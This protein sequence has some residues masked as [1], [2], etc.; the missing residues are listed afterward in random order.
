[1]RIYVLYDY[2]SVTAGARE[3][4]RVAQSCPRREPGRGRTAGTGARRACRLSSRL[5]EE[6]EELEMHAHCFAEEIL[7]FWFGSVGAWDRASAPPADVEAR[8]WNGG[9]TLDAELTRRYR[10]HVIAAATLFEHETRWAMALPPGKLTDAQQRLLDADSACAERG[11]PA[12]PALEPSTYTT[13]EVVDAKHDN[14]KRESA[15]QLI[16]DLA[17]SFIQYDPACPTARADSRARIRDRLALVILLDQFS[18]NI[19]RGSSSAFAFDRFACPL[20]TQLLDSEG[21]LAK[22]YM[23]ALAPFELFFLLMPLEHSEVAAEQT[24]GVEATRKLLEQVQAAEAPSSGLPTTRYFSDV[25]RDKAGRAELVKRFGRY[26]PRNEALGRDS[27]KAE[28]EYLEARQKAMADGA[29]KGKD[30]SNYIHLPQQPA[31]D[32]TPRL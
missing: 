5:A 26:P 4:A 13:G 29:A 9:E 32:T 12:A 2:T 20:V 23:E 8:W 27:T 24:A 19:Y 30:Q 16:L 25:L 31:A 6:R 1:M 22:E 3:H 10:T 21:A 28:V 11:V 14:E 17:R 18:R 7:D 15:S